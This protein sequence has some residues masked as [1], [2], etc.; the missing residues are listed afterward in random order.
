MT[1]K[2]R[3]IIP[4]LVT[5]FNQDESLNE[6]A[7]REII[8]YVIK[9]GVHGIFVVGSQGEFWALSKE[10]KK[11]MFEIAMDEAN[12]AIKVYA[13]T[14]AE[15]TRETVELTKIARDVG[16]D[17]ASI[18]TPYFVRPSAKELIDHYRTI[19][20]QVDLPIV[21]YNNP[22]RTGVR[23][24]SQCVAELA[25]EY[26]NIVGIKDSGG[27]LSLTLEYISK[28]DRKISVLAGCDTLVYSTLVAGGS[29][30]IA[31]TANVV[32]ELAVSIFD[33]AISGDFSR[34]LEAQNRL[35]PLRSAFD[36]G[37]F[38]S[39]V[40]EAVNMIGL[41]AGRCRRPISP[42]NTSSKESL[43]KILIG[44]GVVRTLQ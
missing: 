9:R 26:D 14:G 24:D 12:N 37:T 39:V 31:A 42:L 6:V 15:S 2:P 40:K 22:G 1:F 5:P 35:A 13:G 10:E 19:A 43:R 34:A 32:P 17:V 33:K 20:A 4:A 38:P 23:I 28:P 18:I 3:G 7:A 36:L 41:S 16:V 30:A 27:D 44:S 21:L 29:G 25:E 11:R 8:Q